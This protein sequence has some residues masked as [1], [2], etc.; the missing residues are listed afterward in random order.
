[1]R[2][3][4]TL[5]CNVTRHTAPHATMSQAPKKEVIPRADWE[6]R[7]EQSGVAKDD[8]NKLILNYLVIEGYKDAAEVFCEETHLAPSVNL[9]S[10]QDRMMIRTAIQDGRVDDAVDRVNDLDPDI[11][12][13]NPRLFFHLQQQKLIELIRAGD[14]AAALA[15]AQDELAPRGEEN[16][17]FLAE[18]ERTLA[19][20]VFGQSADSP[21][22]DLLDM[23]QRLK[24]AGEMNASIL[25]AQ[26]Q[27]KD[28]KLPM[29]LRSLAWA[30]STLGEMAVFPRIDDPVSGHLVVPAE[31][32]GPDMQF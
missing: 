13:T 32:E 28:P 16:P 2:T 10:I 17:E 15:F 27:E 29:L 23:A 9:A 30:Q 7:L 31:C 4:P 1:M 26:S 18:L 14:V 5:S 6:A 24:T 12:E 20:L 3:A 11:L 22:A 21:V 8:L 19:L 25:L